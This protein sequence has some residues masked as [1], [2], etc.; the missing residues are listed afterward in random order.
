MPSAVASCG[1]EILTG[2]PSKKNSPSSAEL[3]AGDRLDERRLAGAVVADERDHLTGVD[4]EVDA[5]EG[6]VRAERLAHALQREERRRGF[7]AFIALVAAVTAAR[8]RRLPP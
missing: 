8:L 3:H 7:V 5:G 6:L 4:F 1:L 2:S